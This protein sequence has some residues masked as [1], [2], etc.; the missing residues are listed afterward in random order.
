MKK[1]VYIS[2]TPAQVETLVLELE[3]L[4]VDV[5]AIS[6]IETTDVKYQL[7]TKSYDWIFFFSSNA[8]EYFFVQN[9]TIPKDV[10]FG[11]VGMATAASLEKYKAVSFIGQTSNT[12]QVAAEFANVLA[13][14]IVLVPQSDISIHPLAAKLGKEQ[15]LDLVCYKTSQLPKKIA[16]ADV[17]IFSS[18]SNVQ[19]FFQANTWHE[20]ARAISFGP[21]TSRALREFGVEPVEELEKMN[22]HDL[23]RAIMTVL[24]S[25]E[26]D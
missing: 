22:S 12:D 15:C 7:P 17:F 25:S 14:K 24:C 21:A 4:D 6:L 10:L 23:I 19:S 18:P 11:A 1:R 9:P 2:R 13:S 5:E 20:S 16:S 3:K 8:V 26:E